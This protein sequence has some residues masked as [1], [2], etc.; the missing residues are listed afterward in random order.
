MYKYIYVTQ[1]YFFSIIASKVTT[2]TFLNRVT[3]LIKLHLL[4]YYIKM[5]I[6]MI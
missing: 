5:C 3:K 1:F 4:I 6:E 2:Q